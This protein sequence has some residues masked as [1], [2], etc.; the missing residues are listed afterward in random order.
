M[1]IDNM[2]YKLPIIEPISINMINSITGSKYRANF[3]SFM[4][5]VYG[6]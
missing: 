5:K 1:R 4:G 2:T 6:K 3:D